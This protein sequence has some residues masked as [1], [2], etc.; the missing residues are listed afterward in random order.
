MRCL[1]AQRNIMSLQLQT[2]C[3]RKLHI[4]QLHFM[5]VSQAVCSLGQFS[6]CAIVLRLS[7]PL[8]VG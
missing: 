3:V 4:Y 5:L 8:V 2:Q 7:L 1:Q 6:P